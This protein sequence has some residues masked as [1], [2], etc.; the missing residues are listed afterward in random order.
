VVKVALVQ[1]RSQKTRAE[2]IE[3]AVNLLRKAGAL[4]P[5]IVCLPERQ[6]QVRNSDML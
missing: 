6:L 4:E 1:L 5:D 3:H 2:S